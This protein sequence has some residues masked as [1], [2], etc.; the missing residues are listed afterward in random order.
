MFCSFIFVS[1][2]SN[3]TV[4]IHRPFCKTFTDQASADRYYAGHLIPEPQNVSGSDFQ[5]LLDEYYKSIAA[6]KVQS[7]KTG[8][9]GGGALLIAVYRGK[10]SEGLD[11]IDDNARAVIAIGIPFPS[12]K[13]IQITAKK[14]FNTR[15][16]ASKGLLTGSQ[17]FPHTSLLIC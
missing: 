11:F 17:W 7:D 3:H 14:D 4:E 8:R 1:K 12:A 6:S 16:A 13:D 2:K 15:Y 5:E 10:V 9:D